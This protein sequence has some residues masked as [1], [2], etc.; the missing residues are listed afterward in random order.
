M[1]STSKKINSRIYLNSI[2]KKYSSKYIPLSENVKSNLNFLKRNENS[3]NEDKIEINLNLKNNN[4]IISFRDKN[5]ATEFSDKNDFLN[6]FKKFQ[7]YNTI[8]DK[9]IENLKKK[10]AFSYN[11]SPRINIKNNLISRNNTNNNNLNEINNNNNNLN[12]INNIQNNNKNNKNNLNS[13]NFESEESQLVSSEFG[14]KSKIKNY[15]ESFISIE[16]LNKINKINIKKNPFINLL[17]F[18]DNN[19]LFNFFNLNKFTRNLIINSLKFEIKTFIANKFNDLT[20]NLFNSNKF[21]LIFKKEKYFE[22]FLILKSKISNTNL[23]NKSIH[24]KYKTFF[25]SDKEFNLN[26]NIFDI[27]NSNLKFWVIKENTSFYLDELNKAYIMHIMQ[28]KINDFIEF[29][30]NIFTKKGLMNIR[31][32]KFLKINIFPTPNFDFFEYNK[33]NNFNR[34]IID[35][36]D[37]R[38]CE[39]EF[40]KGNWN[41]IKLFE[42]KNIDDIKFEF[43]NKLFHIEKILFDDVGYYMFKIYLIAVKTGEIFNDEIQI[44]LKV[45]KNNENCSNECKK[46]NLIFDRKNELQLHLGDVLVFYITKNKYNNNNNNMINSLSSTPQKNS[47]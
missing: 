28:Y 30:I 8:L 16:N 21:Y 18:F 44:K 24:F 3:L 19:L 1:N 14:F 11:N 41:D 4:N 35:Y 43:F 37:N 20:K 45:V 40:C 42:D 22:I 15:K 12:E 31:K 10:I 6:N 5:S 38:I 39:I 23:I 25:P 26:H 13:K 27:K 47:V 7:E 46:N 32:L 34:E 17:T 9:K 36:N 29:T 2:T 33:E